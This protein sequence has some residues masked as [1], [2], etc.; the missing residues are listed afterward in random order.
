MQYNRT[1][2]D[3]VD[4]HDAG[5]IRQHAGNDGVAATLRMNMKDMTEG[6]EERPPLL[7]TPPHA[8]IPEPASRHQ[9]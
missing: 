2:L 4:D 7:K 5:P 9:G 3:L 1:C 6:Q 8:V